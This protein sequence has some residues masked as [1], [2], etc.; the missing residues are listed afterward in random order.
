METRR[1]KKCQKQMKPNLPRKFLPSFNRTESI[2]EKEIMNKLAKEKVQ[3]ELK[4]Q[5]VIRY[6]R[7]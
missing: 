6:K 2:V 4:L 3:T 1:K 7:L 5:V